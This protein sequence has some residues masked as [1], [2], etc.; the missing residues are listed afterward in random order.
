MKKNDFTPDAIREELMDYTFNHNSPDD[1]LSE[2]GGGRVSVDGI[3]DIQIES[4]KKSGDNFI[5]VGNAMLETSTDLGEGDGFSDS[6]PMTFSFEFDEN[7]KIVA[8]L[9]RHID[10]SSFFAGNEDIYGDLVG[11]TCSSHLGVFQESL[12]DIRRLLNQPADAPD[13]FLHRL[14]Y[15][16]VITALESY[17]SD[18]LVS[19]VLEHKATLRRFIEKAPVFQSQRISVSEVFKTR[20]T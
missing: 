7:G 1:E 20:E 6:Y 19:R 2:I 13:K 9:S 3:V 4:V 15:V 18:F 12:F 17:L 14:L 8:Q 5:V 11:L 16:H 10:T